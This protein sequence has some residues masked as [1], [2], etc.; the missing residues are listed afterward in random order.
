MR[1]VRD[2]DNT[3]V[4]RATLK[5]E[6]I[7]LTNAQEEVKAAAGD[8]KSRQTGTLF[9]R[10]SVGDV[11]MMTRQLATLVTAGI[12]LVE[13]VGALIEQVKQMP[14]SRLDRGLPRVSFA[15]WLQ[16]EA[17]PDARISW[18]LRYAKATD[19]DGGRDFPTC[20]EADAM[21]ETGRSI[22]ILIGVGRPGKIG[23][24]KAFVYRADLLDQHDSIG[25]NHLRDI[26]AALS[27]FQRTASH[28]EVVR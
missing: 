20:V 17:G 2:A 9:R 16:A 26:P 24:R 28:S 4:L 27:R 23:D 12:P 8:R 3:K 25:L 10:A 15:K 13:S 22:V 19:T 18:V 1:G 7:L 6:G 14:A 5:R 11:A 21:M